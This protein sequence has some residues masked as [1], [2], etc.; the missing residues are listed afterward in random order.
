[1]RSQQSLRPLSHFFLRLDF[2]PATAQVIQP[3]AGMFAV[4]ACKITSTIQPI[5]GTD[6]FDRFRPLNYLP[7]WLWARRPTI[8]ILSF[9]IRLDARPPGS[10]AVRLRSVWL[11][12]MEP[13]CRTW[14]CTRPR[15]PRMVNGSQRSHRAS[16]RIQ[17]R[18][19][20]FDNEQVLAG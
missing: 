9:P 20:Q 14:A 1:M 6:R 10:G 3:S 11:P 17:T 16:M 4:S 19:R 12:R 8:L 15:S 18:E 13:V 5:E 2:I 7:T